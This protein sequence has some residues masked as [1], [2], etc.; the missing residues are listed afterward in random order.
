MI[1]KK[2]EKNDIIKAMYA[3]STIC[4]TTYNKNTKELI[5]IFNKGGRYKY[6][7]VSMTDYTRVETADS[8]G[9]S[10]NTYIKKNY[11]NFEKMDDVDETTLKAILA[12]IKELLPEEDKIDVDKLT[13]IMMGEMCTLLNEYVTNGYISPKNF[14]TV[15]HTMSKY[16]N[17]TEAPANLPS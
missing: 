17:K 3:S 14:Q 12:E 9:T 6:P 11:T 16:K 5:V 13:K 2:I 8:N 4:A 1:V 10:F 7:N 15:F